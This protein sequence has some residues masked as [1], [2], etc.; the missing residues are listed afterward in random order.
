MIPR[1]RNGFT[2]GLT[3]QSPQRSWKLYIHN[4][5]RPQL[6]RMS[7][8]KHCKAQHWRCDCGEAWWIIAERQRVVMN[9]TPESTRLRTILRDWYGRG[10]ECRSL[11][12]DLRRI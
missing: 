3:A 6:P 10:W 7:F 5:M 9:T 4:S 1:K 8:S 12:G 2:M 11:I